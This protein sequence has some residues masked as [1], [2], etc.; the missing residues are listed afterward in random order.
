VQQFFRTFIAND[1]LIA[2]QFSKSFHRGMGSRASHME[3]DDESDGESM[4]EE[5]TTATP[6]HA[7][8][9]FAPESLSILIEINSFLS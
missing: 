1:F 3:Y 4:K 5:S 9:L 8:P 7:H 2:D 6:E